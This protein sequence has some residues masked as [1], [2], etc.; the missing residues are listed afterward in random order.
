MG[1][2]P[3]HEC[4]VLIFTGMSGRQAE[5]Q[6]F[7][8]CWAS[9]KFRAVASIDAVCKE[10]QSRKFDKAKSPTGNKFDLAGRL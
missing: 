2:E 1:F 6:V 4:R 5:K 8:R 9:Q 3:F 7:V 10:G